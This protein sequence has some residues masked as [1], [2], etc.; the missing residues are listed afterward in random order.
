MI[1]ARNQDGKGYRKIASEVNLVDSTVGAI[2]IKWKKTGGVTK[3]LQRIGWP[4][5][6]SDANTRYIALKVK[7]DL[8]M[9]HS[10]IQKDLQEAGIE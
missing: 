1:Y 6:L 9:T 2:V 10:E 4:R 8:F 7:K 5:I 3:N